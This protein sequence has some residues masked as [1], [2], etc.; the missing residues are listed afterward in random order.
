MGEER[1][2]D[3]GDFWIGKILHVQRTLQLSVV[4]EWKDFSHVRHA[5]DSPPPSTRSHYEWNIV[6]EGR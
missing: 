2:D 5:A 6:R 4:L 1:G 3:F